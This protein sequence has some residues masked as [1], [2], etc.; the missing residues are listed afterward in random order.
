MQL[1]VFYKTYPET[2]RCVSCNKIGRIRRSRSRNVF[3]S[4]IKMTRIWGIY[5]CRECGWR[6]I[7]SKISLSSDSFITIILYIAI[8]VVV[9]YI[10]IKILKRNFGEI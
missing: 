1:K 4:L 2:S 8:I 10:L 6:G 9:A 3:E 5:K 7:K